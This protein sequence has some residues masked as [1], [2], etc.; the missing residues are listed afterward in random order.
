MASSC[1]IG[2]EYSEA[3]GSLENLL[4]SSIQKVYRKTIGPRYLVVG[5]DYAW[6]RPSCR[7]PVV[8]GDWRDE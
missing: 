3:S 1:F 8:I 4:K 6:A 5:L 7:I 2:T